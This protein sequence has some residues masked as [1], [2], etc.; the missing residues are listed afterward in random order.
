MNKNLHRAV[1]IAKSR[2]HWIHEYL[3]AKNDRASVD[4]EELAAFR[5]LAKRYAKLTGKQ[6]DLLLY[7]K[8]L[9]EI[10]HDYKQQV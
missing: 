9:T 1:I 5:E 7:N 10:C 3:F 2:R 8:D 4:R 6:I